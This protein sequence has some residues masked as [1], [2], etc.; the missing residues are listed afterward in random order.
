MLRLVRLTVTLDDDD[1]PPMY[2]VRSPDV[3]GLVTESETLAGALEMA[4]DA[5]RAIGRD[6]RADGA[7]VPPR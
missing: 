6:A 1:A 7:P 3:P 4:A 2:L 5:L